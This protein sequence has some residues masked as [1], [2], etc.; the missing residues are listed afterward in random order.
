MWKIAQDKVCKLSRW[1]V[2]LLVV[3]SHVATT[4]GDAEISQTL[5][6][7]TVWTVWCRSSNIPVWSVLCK[8]DHLILWACQERITLSPSLERPVLHRAL[9][10]TVEISKLN[11]KA[12]SFIQ[13]HIGKRRFHDSH[14]FR[15]NFPRKFSY[16]F[17]RGEFYLILQTVRGPTYLPTLDWA[18]WFWI[19]FLDDTSLCDSPHMADQWLCHLTFS[20]L[21]HRYS[22]RVGTGES[23]KH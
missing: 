12:I 18:G 20:P 22:D 9:K 10:N 17:Q 16:H 4:T 14:T 2:W 1:R 23:R 8:D 6:K 13:K 5:W 11:S 19:V 7:S 21:Y 3:L 15:R